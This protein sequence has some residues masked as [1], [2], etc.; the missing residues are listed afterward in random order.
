MPNIPSIVNGPRLEV[1]K[2]IEY[3]LPCPKC[4]KEMRVT[5][6]TEGSLIECKECGNITWRMAYTPP[7]WAKTSRFIISILLA[8][9]LGIGSSLVASW[10]YEKYSKARDARTELNLPTATTK[11]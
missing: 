11:R 1:K 5:G 4:A 9:I 10:I 6:V 7:W 8:F 3:D 2:K